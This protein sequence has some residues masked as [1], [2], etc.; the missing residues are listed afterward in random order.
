MLNKARLNYALDVVIAF[1]FI[2]SSLS[3]IA[4]MFMG[5]GGYQG[6]RNPDFQT[7]LLG[8]S[9]SNWSDLHA[10]TG[11]VMVV[12]VLIHLVFHWNWIVC[13]TKQLLKPARR[14]TQEACPVE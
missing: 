10:L 9:R 5:S 13:M 8:I 11:L 7:E 3:G 1:A 4:F 2:L 14:Q 12:G 6:G